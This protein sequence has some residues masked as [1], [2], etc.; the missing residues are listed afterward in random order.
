MSPSAELV[1]QG[2]SDAVKT[3]QLQSGRKRRTSCCCCFFF[4]YSITVVC[5]FSPSLHPTP[6]EPTSTLPLGFV[7]VS[8]REGPLVN[9]CLLIVQISLRTPSGQVV[10]ESVGLCCVW[11]IL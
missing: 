11:P 2:A 8:F 3:T 4:C 7:H 10:M 1:G 5:L 9:G 6:G